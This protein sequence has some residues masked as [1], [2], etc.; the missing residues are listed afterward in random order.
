[1]NIPMSIVDVK[2]DTIKVEGDIED[3]GDLNTNK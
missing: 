1:M 2:A 3:S